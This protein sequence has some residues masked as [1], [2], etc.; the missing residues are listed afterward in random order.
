M[1]KEKKMLKKFVKNLIATYNVIKNN[2]DLKNYNDFKEAFGNYFNLNTSNTPSSWIYDCLDVYGKAFMKANFKL[3]NKGTYKQYEVKPVEKH[4]IVEIFNY[5]N[6]YQS[7]KSILYKSAFHLGYYG[8]IYFHKWR[9]KMGVVRQI[10]QLHPSSVSIVSNNSLIDYYQVNTG[11][12]IVDI[13]RADIIHIQNPDPD[14]YVKGKAIVSNILEQSEVDKLQVEYMKQFYKRGGFLGLTFST[15]LNLNAESFK[16]SLKQLENI[17]GGLDNA[18]KVTLLDNDLKPMNVTHSM[19]EMDLTTQRALSRDEILAAFQINKFQLGMSEGTQR[20]NA[21]ENAMR[22]IADV[23]DPYL[24]L[25]ADGFTKQLCLNEKG[26]ETYF[27][28][29]ISTS[30]RDLEADLQWYKVMTEV[31]G[32]TPELIFHMEKTEIP[33]NLKDDLRMKEPLVFKKEIKNKEDLDNNQNYKEN[34]E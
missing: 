26:W 3:F 10:F 21:R 14:N 28:E 20:G 1:K 34:E 6:E 19:R 8:N 32:I 13:P 33:E 2:Y 9:D 11:R 12:G 25:M 15:P 4:P 27:I 23:I 17:Y 22:F 5:P 29:H 24:M 31:G 16:K 18:Y 7:W 30:P